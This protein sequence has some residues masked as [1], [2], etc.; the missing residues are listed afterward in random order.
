MLPANGSA[1]FVLINV[2]CL[3]GSSALFMTMYP[4]TVNVLAQWQNARQQSVQSLQVAVSGRNSI[5]GDDGVHVV[6]GSNPPLCQLILVVT[7]QP[8]F[9]RMSAST[10]EVVPLLAG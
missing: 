2:V 4:Y 1:S 3:T 8:T 7:T 6:T 9:Y 10:G 5:C